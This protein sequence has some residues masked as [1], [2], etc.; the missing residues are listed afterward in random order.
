MD[1][2][3]CVLKYIEIVPLD[4]NVGQTEDLKPFEVKVCIVTN[5]VNLCDMGCTLTAVPR[6]TQ[7]STLRGMVNEYQPHGWV[8]IHGNGWIFGL[9]QSTDRLSTHSSNLR[10]GDHLVLTSFHSEYRSELLHMAMY[11]WWWHYKY[12]LFAK[13]V[14]D[15]F[16]VS[17]HAAVFCICNSS[18]VY[19]NILP[20]K[21]SDF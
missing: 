7:P 9:L 3:S 4:S 11:H 10:V 5:L 20:I 15:F 1:D 13:N 12:C 18:N 6:S 16:P 17:T 2:D 14:R 19:K 8:I 21:V